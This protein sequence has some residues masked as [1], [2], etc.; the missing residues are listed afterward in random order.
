[1]ANAG[2]AKVLKEWR[3]SEHEEFAPRTA[4]SLHNSYTEVFKG[5]N[6]V[7]LTARSLRLHGLMDLIAT[8]GGHDPEQIDLMGGIM[9]N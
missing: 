6:P 5:S 8:E 2:I 1:M 9:V 3:G 7:D 4:W